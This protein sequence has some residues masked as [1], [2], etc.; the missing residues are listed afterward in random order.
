[1]S[2]AELKTATAKATAFLKKDALAIIGVEYKKH[3]QRSFQRDQQ[4]FTDASLVKW[5]P[6]KPETL[7]RVT[8]RSGTAPPI[9]TNDG[10]LRDSIDWEADYGQQAAVLSTDKPYAQVHNEGGGPNN[11]PKRQFMG[12]SKKLEET[13]VKKFERELDKIFN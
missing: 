9:L 4:G 13:I 3:F 10:H 6:L 2:P 1:M 11:M 12:P 7:K 8:R 5:Q